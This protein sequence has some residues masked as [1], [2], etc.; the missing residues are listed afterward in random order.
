MNTILDATKQ[1]GHKAIILWLT[2]KVASQDLTL[3]IKPDRDISLMAG[4]YERYDD[5][6]GAGE[7]HYPMSELLCI[8]LFQ[9]REDKLRSITNSTI[10]ITDEFIRQ[11]EHLE[12]PLNKIFIECIQREKICTSE[13]KDSTAI[14]IH[15][16]IWYIKVNN[17][18]TPSEIL[19]PD[20]EFNTIQP[21]IDLMLLR[22]A[23]KGTYEKLED[24]IESDGRTLSNGSR[25]YELAM[26]SYCLNNDKNPNHINFG[27][28]AKEIISLTFIAWNSKPDYIAMCTF[29]HNEKG[30]IYDSG[31]GGRTEEVDSNL[32]R[33]RL[34]QNGS[35]S[36]QN[37]L[38]ALFNKVFEKT[39][40]N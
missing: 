16:K 12:L 32:M 2:S 18:F 28:F 38:R 1:F 23:L 33:K 3:L 34:T 14:Y 35:K 27:L 7:H 10:I 21:Y 26:I 9:E 29:K 6:N 5:I 25:F 30:L 24:S 22:K 40:L 19:I 37:N 20:D 15:D 8:N 39:V 13:S 11:I 17:Q 31:Y 36:K 4:R